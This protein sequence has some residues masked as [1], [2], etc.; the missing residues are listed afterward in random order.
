MRVGDKKTY[1]RRLGA[2]WKKIEIESKPI[3]GGTADLI[4]ATKMKIWVEIIVL[5]SVSDRG[6]KRLDKK[7]RK[8]GEE[9]IANWADE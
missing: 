8:L 5:C 4:N 3:A 7:Y 9:V 6:I 2:Q 1:V